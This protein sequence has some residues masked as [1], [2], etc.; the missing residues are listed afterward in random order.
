MRKRFLCCILV[1]ALALQLFGCGKEEGTGESVSDSTDSGSVFGEENDVPYDPGNLADISAISGLSG[2][3]NSLDAYSAV[4]NVLLPVEQSEGEIGGARKWFLGTSKAYFFCK[5]VF[6]TPEASW[7]ELASVT[8]QG[9]TASIRWNQG[10]WKYAIGPILGS[11]HYFVVDVA[12]NSDSWRLVEMDEND[13]AV[14]E[15][16]LD[17]LGSSNEN[18]VYYVMGDAAGCIHLVASTLLLRLDQPPGDNYYYILSPEGDILTE[19]NCGLE[20][21]KFIPIYDGTVAFETVEYQD[22]ARIRHL[23]RLDAENGEPEELMALEEPFGI[24]YYAYTLSDAD[25]MVYANDIGV[26]RRGLTEVSGESLYLWRNHGLTVSG[27]NAMQL[28][29]DD[30]IALIYESKGESNYLYLEPTT[31]EVEIRQITLAASPYNAKTYQAMAT[32]FNRKYPTCHVEVKSD[33]EDTAL[34]TE[35]IAGNGPILCDTALVSFEDH[36]NLWEPL[37]RVLEGLGI[38]GELQESAMEFGKIDGAF[39]GV[40]TYFWLETVVAGKDA[41]ENWD[42]GEFLECIEKQPE[43]ETVFNCD[44]AGNYGISFI[45]GFLMHNLQDNYFIDAEN[46]ETRFD[47]EEFRKILKLAERYCSPKGAIPPGDALLEGRTLC[48]TLIIQHPEQLALYRLCYGEDANYIG[49][50]SAEGSQ[51][52]INGQA[53]LTIRKTATKEEKE[54][55]YAFLGTMLSYEGQKEASKDI[56]FGLSVRKDVLEEQIDSMNEDSMPHANGFEQIRLGDGLDKEQDRET[57]YRLLDSA[58]PRRGFPRQLNEIFLDE[59]DAY[60]EGTITEDMLIDHLEN[61]VNLYLSEQ[62]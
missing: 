59:L 51:H 28:V 62:Q 7:D 6:D 49:Y 31:E 37:D 58:R 23:Q 8:L 55:A 46:G 54:V 50:P 25:T 41:P 22:S 5:H 20:T 44:P 45:L 57:L 15:I 48:N 36:K 18:G 47:S 40:V 27:V 32:E 61:R 42:Y 53:P 29:G 14:R 13:T 2:K 3:D 4:T 60:F 43:I 24:T 11:D 30:R 52:Y 56:N 21:I 33:Y 39:Y 1:S 9:E 17:F 16:P 35:L 38:L 34:L 12:D 10:E 26:Y 19:C